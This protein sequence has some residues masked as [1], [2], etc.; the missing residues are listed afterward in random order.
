MDKAEKVA[1]QVMQTL[2]PGAKLI[3]HDIGINCA[4]DF[5]LV[6]PTGD[7]YPLEVTSATDRS[8]RGTTAAILDEEKGRQFIQGKLCKTSWYVQPT[9]TARINDIRKHADKYLAAL[10]EEGIEEF[11]SPFEVQSVAIK[12]IYHDLGVEAAWITQSQQPQ[13]ICIGLP[14]KIAMLGD[15]APAAE[16]AL[17]EARKEDNRRKLAQVT[18]L[19]RHLFVYIDHSCFAAWLAMNRFEPPHSMALL[20]PEITDIWVGAQRRYPEIFVVWKARAGN[21]WENKGSIRV[22]TV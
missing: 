3:L 12:A 14:N 11:F 22:S 16:A 2:I 20:P 10:E 4:Y 15:G 6:L 18:A 1:M 5:D 19:R 21:P 7:C 9:P 8:A 13:C 17:A